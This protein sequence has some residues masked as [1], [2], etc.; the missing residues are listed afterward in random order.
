MSE[1]MT[2]NSG[3]RLSL[4][5]RGKLLLPE[6]VLNNSLLY[7]YVD[8]LSANAQHDRERAFAMAVDAFR[9]EVRSALTVSPIDGETAE[10]YES[11]APFIVKLLLYIGKIPTDAKFVLAARLIEARVRD[12]SVSLTET[13]QIIAV[14]TGVSYPTIKRLAEDCFDCYD[15]GETAR[16]SYLT[17][18]VPNSATEAV[19]DLAV[20]VRTKMSKVDEVYA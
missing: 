9:N 19:C 11:V 8:V 2:D 6:S 17:G 18:I 16:I 14:R 3:Y 10:R 4:C 20:Y 1:K 15:K 13:E 7:G 12:P 5:D